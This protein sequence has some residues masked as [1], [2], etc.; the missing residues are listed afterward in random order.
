MCMSRVEEIVMKSQVVGNV[1]LPCARSSVV[2]MKED[3]QGYNVTLPV[4]HTHSEE[5]KKLT[6][7]LIRTHKSTESNT[8]NI[9][10]QLSVCTLYFALA[11]FCHRYSAYASISDHSGS[12]L[13]RFQLHK[14]QT[15]NQ[16]HFL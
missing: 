4:R 1:E 5:Y 6:H 11:T 10:S 15:T 2:E 14:H 7:C 8:A 9:Q 16:T 13:V 12:I 3:F